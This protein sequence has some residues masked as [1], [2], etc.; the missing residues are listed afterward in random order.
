MKIKSLIKWVLGALVFWG[1]LVW[2]PWITKSFAEKKAF[3]DF[4]I[5]QTGLLTGCTA[6]CEGC[7]VVDSQKVPFGYKIIIKFQCGRDGRLWQTEKSVTA[8]AEIR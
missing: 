6:D 1:M 4:K 2:C 7:G 5:K 3:N 8:F